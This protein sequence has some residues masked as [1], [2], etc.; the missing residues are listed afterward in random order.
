MLSEIMEKGQL[1]PLVS[2]PQRD[3][4]WR[5]SGGPAWM[6][7][8]KAHDTSAGLTMTFPGSE[9]PHCHWQKIPS[10]SSQEP[11]GPACRRPSAPLPTPPESS[12]PAPALHPPSTPT[13]LSA[14]IHPTPSCLECSFF[15]SFQTLLTPSDLGLPPTLGSRPPL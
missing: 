10:R 14:H 9:S 5:G 7:T 13:F 1:V 4:G 11:P 3:E 15:L 6:P 2:G 8:S 12:P